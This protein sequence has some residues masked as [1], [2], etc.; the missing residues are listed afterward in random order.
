MNKRLLYAGLVTLASIFVSFSLR[1]STDSSLKL[2]Y[3][4]Q[5]L[6]N[7]QVEDVTGNGYNGTL[8]NAAVLS[9]LDSIG[10]LKLG[11][12]NGYLDMGTAVGRLVD[13]LTDF[14]VSTYLFIDEAADISGNGN[15][16]WSFSDNANCGQYAGK[17]VAYRVNAQRY[18]LSTGGWA[19]EKVGISYGSAAQKGSWQHVC[20]TQNG[21]TGY[22]YVNGN[23]LKSGTASLAPSSLST[24]ILYNWI[25]RSPFSS[26]NYLKEASLAD[27]RI[28]NRYL[29]P[30][31]VSDLA[32]NS[33]SLSS[34]YAR[35][36]LKE[37]AASLKL[38]DADTVQTSIT[39]P[40][41]SNDMVTLEW[42]SSDPVALSNDGVVT[43]PAYGNLPVSVQLTAIL[44]TSTDSVHKVFTVVVLPWQSDEASVQIDM[45][46]LCL[47]GN[48]SALRDNLYLPVTGPEGSTITWNSSNPAY[49]SNQGVLA[50]SPAKGEGPMT[51]QLTAT[52]RK[53]TYSA[54]RLFDVTLAEE[55][56]CSS[57]L[58]VY[59][60]GNSGD[61]E[62]IR[63]ALSPDGYNYR[64]LNN[65]LP[66]ISSD[67]IAQM[68]AV[69]DPHIYRGVDSC[70][71]MVV[72]DMKSA[73]GWS[74]NHA[75][76]LLK[77]SDLINWSHSVVDIAATYPEYSDVNRVWAPQTIWDPC[78]GKYM[79]YWSQR[80]GSDPD[81]IHY[82]Y[83]NKDFTTLETAP[84]VLFNHPDNQACIDGDILYRNGLFNLFFKTE[85][86]GNGIMKAVSSSLTGPYVLKEAKYLQQTT[87]PVEGACI[88]PL[89]KSDT[90]I[91]MYDVYTSGKYEFTRTTDLENFRIQ[92]GVS[93]NFAPRHGTVMAITAE[94][95]AAL[96][97]KWGKATDLIVMSVGS[98]LAKRLNLVIDNNNRTVFVPVK[99]GTDLTAFD[100]MIQAMPGVSVTPAGPQNFSTGGV[101]YVLSLNGIKVTYYVTAS[102]NNNPVLTDLYA[103]PEVL[104]SENTGKFYIYPTSD[105]YSG[106]NGKYFNCF[107][108]SDLVNWANEGTIIDLTSGQV[109][110]A[111][112]NAWAPC[113]VEKKIN[114]QY[115][116][117]FYF[118]AAQ[119]IGVAVS[120]SPTG[121]FVDSGKALISSK[122]SGITGGQE[123]DP[124]V[125][126]DPVSGKS[127]LYWGNG[128]MAGAELNDDMISIKSGTTTVLTPD[129][130]FREGTYVIYRNGLYYFMW[131]ENDTGSPDYRVRYGTSTSP[132]GKITV[133]VNNVVIA[134]NDAL[135][136]YGTGHNSVVQLPGKDEW[137]LVYHRLTRPNGINYAS[138]GY[139]REVCIDTLKFNADGSI[140]PVTPTLNGISP[141]STGTTL[142]ILK[143]IRKW[144]TLSPN[145]VKD[146]LRISMPGLADEKLTV[147][148]Q[149]LSGK[150]V[151]KTNL[152]SLQTSLDCSGLVS[153]LYIIK[154]TQGACTM[155]GKFIKS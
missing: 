134:R 111:S 87:S 105:G 74:S 26:D 50:K 62:A 141:V 28:Y 118:T 97:K 36:A 81:V 125:F 8:C 42:L 4:F 46:K 104:Y 9:K 128:Y 139:Y 114:G 35:E 67:T 88:F 30:A 90:C 100:P 73:N 72:T 44:K 151:L 80:A 115:T 123:I 113:I 78:V 56:A 126:T 146:E 20:Y 108:S 60:T 18:A 14:A 40:T 71:Y 33:T 91:L 155:Y 57:Y 77:S 153:G 136:I 132:L 147:E 75:M 149:A 1:A 68:K 112:T 107:S 27:F 45:N 92:N 38:T 86:N 34:M 154:A 79:I 52:V 64:A 152:P 41:I 124:D 95:A 11:S 70:Y 7:G 61:Q 13:S 122:P 144:L 37:V 3:T 131:S 121:P 110:W 148:I 142:P 12:D 133:P 55:L 89:I 127:Y 145:P 2:H 99:Q 15:F 19:N 143:R 84:K 140:K 101:T 93:M 109:S 138:P 117:F 23:L 25:G 47:Y 6:K 39:L 16:L 130:T 5:S 150:T 54:T 66:I 51:I 103:D 102:V 31:E 24:T 63:F 21:T 76:V 53:S 120:S 17:Y 65:N 43:R 49:L 82:A 98:K 129:A 29:S 116:Y 83:A 48:L 69:R 119:K 10:V 32:A 135:A 58:F 96:A 137:Y 94:E 22:L 85:G 106:W 59:F